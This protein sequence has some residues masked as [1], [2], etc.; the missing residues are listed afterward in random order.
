MSDKYGGP[1]ASEND[2]IDAAL[3]DGTLKELKVSDFSRGAAALIKMY[4]AEA[5]I[6]ETPE[7]EEDIISFPTPV[8][9]FVVNSHPSD[10]PELPFEEEKAE[11]KKSD[12]FPGLDKL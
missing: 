12:G 11:D 3:R 4:K 9:D 1:Y 10:Q 2:V 5:K 8:G 7:G 6:T